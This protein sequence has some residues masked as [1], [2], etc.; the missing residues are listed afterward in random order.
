M[1]KWQPKAWSN[2][3]EYIVLRGAGLW[4]VCFI[5]AVVIDKVLVTDRYKVDDML[6]ILRSGKNWDWSSGGDFKGYSGRGGALEISKK[7]ASHFFADQRMST[8][9]FYKRIM[10]DD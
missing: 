6:Q 10:E 2:P 9:E 7:V 1:K 4:A 3:R 8:K 5:G